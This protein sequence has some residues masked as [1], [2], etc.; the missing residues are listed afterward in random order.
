MCALA[1]KLA[2]RRSHS[3]NLLVIQENQGQRRDS[4]HC[5][6]ARN[7]G[8]DL[9]ASALHAAI[10]NNMHALLQP[11]ADLMSTDAVRKSAALLTER[12]TVSTTDVQ[13]PCALM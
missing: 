10:A 13:I 4:L 2:P 3:Y 7:A 11:Y 12:R 6:L 5:V 9:Q 8:D 1:L